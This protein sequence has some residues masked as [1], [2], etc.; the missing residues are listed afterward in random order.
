[1]KTFGRFYD[2]EIVKRKDEFA[3]NILDNVKL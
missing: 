2:K 3:L 1:M